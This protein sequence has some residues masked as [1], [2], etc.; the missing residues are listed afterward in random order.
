MAFSMSRLAA[1]SFQFRAYNII[2]GFKGSQNGTC[3][4]SNITKVQAPLLNSAKTYTFEEMQRRAPLVMA[5]AMAMSGL[6]HLFKWRWS[7]DGFAFVALSGDFLGTPVYFWAAFIVV[8]V[9]LLVFDL[10]ILHRD[11]H[12]IE[13]KESLLLYGFMS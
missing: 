6:L 12:E 5:T 7:G 8:V 1:T 2:N 13:A 10:G 9:G 4:G 3:T 11:E